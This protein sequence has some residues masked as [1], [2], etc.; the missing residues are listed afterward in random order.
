[1]LSI[2]KI[3]ETKDTCRF[4]KVTDVA[5]MTNTY[6]VDVWSHGFSNW[7]NIKTMT[8]GC[9]KAH[10]NNRAYARC[11]NLYKGIVNN[12]GDFQNSTS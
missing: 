5:N 8:V 10:E 9:G 7:V 4:Y 1:M 11:F 3:L 2:S 6:K 12:Y